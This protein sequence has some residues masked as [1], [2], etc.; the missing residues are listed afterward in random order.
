MT[1]PSAP[2]G[3][4][5][6]R[7]PSPKA[8]GK[9]SPF[10]SRRRNLWNTRTTVPNMQR[11]SAAGGEGVL[12]SEVIPSSQGARVSNLAP[13]GL[14]ENDSN[15]RGDHR[16]RS[17]SPFLQQSYLAAGTATSAARRRASVKRSQVGLG[18]GPRLVA[19]RGGAGP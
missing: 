18:T 9:C 8:T 7:P 1:R 19:S 2:P 4:S 3:L 16:F 17:D 15:G 10:V 14:Q 11:A 5:A 13:G 12:R 6:H